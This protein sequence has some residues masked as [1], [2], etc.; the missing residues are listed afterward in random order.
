MQISLIM[1]IGL[2]AKNA[3]LIVEY[4]KQRREAGMSLKRSAVEGAEAR[5]RPIIMT[6]LALVIGLLPLLFSTGAG[7]N[8]NYSL[9]VAAIGGMAIGTLFQVFF[10]PGLFILF[11]Y[12]HEKVSP[13]KKAKLINNEN[14]PEIA[15]SKA[16]E[17]ETK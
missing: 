4:S 12:L 3:I 14:H 1:L 13:M 7:A 6:S 2:L 16:L 17:N 5:L 11:R 8:S 10:V 15:S 9:G